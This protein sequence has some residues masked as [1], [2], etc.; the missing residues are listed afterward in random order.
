MYKIEVGTLED[1]KSLAHRCIESG[2][3]DYK[4]LE[5]C[6]IDKLTY[7]DKTLALVGYKKIE[8]DEYPGKPFLVVSG[9]F[10]K[11]VSKHVRVLKE[12]G[13]PYL[14]SIQKYPLIALAQEEDSKYSKFLESFGFVFTKTVEKDAETGIMYKVYVRY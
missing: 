11:T 8:F 9:V 4:A 1:Y 6:H 5:G 14:D 2:K 13:V 12:C 10:D 7:N 3:L